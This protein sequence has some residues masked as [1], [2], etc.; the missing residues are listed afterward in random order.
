[1]GQKINP[2]ALRLGHNRNQESS[3]YSGLYYKKCIALDLLFNEYYNQFLKHFKLP[4]GRIGVQ[5]G[6]HQLRAFPFICIPKNSRFLRSR[7]FQLALPKTIQKSSNNFKSLIEEKKYKIKTKSYLKDPLALFYIYV[8]Q[9]SYAISTKN[10]LTT[11]SFNS[12]VSE[13]TINIRGLPQVDLIDT[14]ALSNLKD[15]ENFYKFQVFLYRYKTLWNSYSTILSAEE[16]KSKNELLLDFSTKANPRYKKLKSALFSFN[17]STLQKRTNSLSNLSLLDQDYFQKNPDVFT[18][19]LSYQQQQ[20][21]SKSEIVYL[22]PTPFKVQSH[23]ETTM[24]N[25]SNLQVQISPFVISNDWQSASYLADEIVYFLE[26]RIH[27]IRIKNR[28]LRQVETLPWIKGLRI[29]CSGR[30]G[31]KGKRAQRAS[32]EYFKYGETPLHVFNR[33]IDFASRTAHTPFGSLGVKVWI[34]YK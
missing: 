18:N 20:L 33:K 24:S 10:K 27:F 15:F 31:G 26:K 21:S 30:L 29:I 9:L 14:I 13:N 11:K 25:Y 17:N 2:I 28:L 3:W 12:L 4:K 6:I 22:I 23:L 1:M 7:S 16:L 34:C 19:I 5:L 32:Q 8:A